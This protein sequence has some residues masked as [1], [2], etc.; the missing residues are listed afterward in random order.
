ML[1]LCSNRLEVLEWP[2]DRSRSC[3]RPVKARRPLQFYPVVPWEG[4][5]ENPGGS[6]CS[7]Y[8]G[9]VRRARTVLDQQ[10]LYDCLTDRHVPHL[11]VFSVILI[12]HGDG[13]SEER[14]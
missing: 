8:G 10:R 11:P 5:A 1:A 13:R 6:R 2:P 12:N 14:R 7:S 9:A 3:V 4:P